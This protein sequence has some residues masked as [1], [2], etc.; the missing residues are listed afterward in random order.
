[1]ETEKIIEKMQYNHEYTIA[2]LEQHNKRLFI[3]CLVIFIA[4]I[5]T[6]GAWIVYENSYE[7]VVSESYTTTTD[8]ENAV[9][10]NGNGDLTYGADNISENKNSP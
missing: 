7:D 2:K 5:L 8:G 3:L 1:M 9:F 6:N 4:L 10:V